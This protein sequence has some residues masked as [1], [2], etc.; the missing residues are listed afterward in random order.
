MT[1]P[2][3]DTELEPPYI[4]PRGAEAHRL[5]T[6]VDAAFAFALTLL[7]VS[8]DE[9]PESFEELRYAMRSIPA[10]AASFAVIVMVWVG[11]R[12]WSRRY[13]LDDVPTT[14]IS[15]ALVL[16]VMVYVY[17][18]RALMGA[19]LNAVTGGWVPANFTLTSAEDVRGLFTVYGAGFAATIGCLVLL[20]IHALRRAAALKLT[21]YEQALTRL[22]IVIWCIVGGMGLV[23][24]IMAQTL[25]DRLVGLCGWIYCL[26][27]IV[28]PITAI[29]LGKRAEALRQPLV[30]Q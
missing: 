9:I 22:E 29:A 12:N 19:T 5:D 28:T 21:P 4:R 1:D 23:S 17:P 2:S 27:G 8:F 11:H 15:L 3:D 13:G 7:V 6:F 25:P 16:I 20:N 26:L 18:L 30:R 14:L 10:F 24:V